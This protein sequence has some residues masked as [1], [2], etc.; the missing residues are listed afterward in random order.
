MQWILFLVRIDLTPPVEGYVKDGAVKGQDIRYSS[1]AA[2]VG[3]NWDGYTDPESGIRDYRLS[4]Y[5]V[6][7]GNDNEIDDDIMFQSAS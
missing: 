7:K 1:E 2:S 4:V 5:K 3:A 6:D